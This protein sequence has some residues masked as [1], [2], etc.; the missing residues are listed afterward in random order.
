[1]IYGYARVSTDDQ[2]LTIQRTALRQAGCAMIREEK[3][4]GT[5]LDGRAELQTLLRLH[6][7]WRHFRCDAHRPPRPE[8][9]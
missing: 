9:A 6:T 8:R 5:K 3:R 4:S 7:A 1:M 2:D